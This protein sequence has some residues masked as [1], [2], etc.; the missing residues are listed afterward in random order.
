MTTELRIV[1]FP[2]SSLLNQL[3]PKNP[4]WIDEAT[5]KALR[6][7]L[8]EFSCVEPIIFNTRTSQVVGGHQRIKA[9]AANG[10]ESLPTVLIDISPEEEA[11][12]NIALNKI[13]GEWDYQ[14]LSSIL[15]DLQDC[16]IDLQVTGF[17]S[18]E[19]D[20]ICNQYSRDL[21][22]VIQSS[23]GQQAQESQSVLERFKV[24][25]DDVDE[26]E[27]DD[28]LD[29][30]LDDDETDSPQTDAID[31][32]AKPVSSTTTTTSAA[33]APTVVATTND[34]GV[35]RSADPVPGQSVIESESHS[36]SATPDPEQDD[37]DSDEVV[38]AGDATSGST[39]ISSGGNSKQVTS[40]GVIVE[41]RNFSA[42]EA[43]QE[44]NKTIKIQFGLFNYKVPPQVYQLWLEDI[45]NRS[46]NGTS[47]VALG[48]VVAE[49]LGLNNEQE[50][51]N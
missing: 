38:T 17:T 5:F 20:V 12:F 43:S 14:K 48:S 29:D 24:E 25:L 2:V 50:E 19:A 23:S 28:E 51:T 13:R 30:E 41:A 49:M 31:V 21:D 4:R 6:K 42:K 27:F 32:V 35:E 47:P 18:E 1:D 45:K 39:A 46:F 22:V 26:D 8:A 34:T 9:A 40:N 37:S 7:S 16:G 3:N 36:S 10:A 15:A 11:A 33:P 44:L